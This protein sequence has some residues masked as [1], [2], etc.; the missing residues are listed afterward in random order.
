MKIYKKYWFTLP[1]LVVVITVLVVLSTV[2]FLTLITHSKDARDTVRISDMENIRTAMDTFYINNKIFPDPNWISITYSWSE[3]WN[4]WTISDQVI[5]NL[6]QI[7]KKPSDPLTDWEYPYSRLNS[8][9]QFQIWTIL[10]KSQ[11]LNITN[12][13]KAADSIW[14]IN[15]WHIYLEWNYNSLVSSVNIWNKIYALVVPAIITSDLTNTDFEY[16]LENRKILYHG[17][18]YNG[19]FVWL[20]FTPYSIVAYEWSWKELSNIKEQVKLMRTVKDLYCS[21]N[22]LEEGRAIQ[23]LLTNVINPNAPSFEYK[24]FANKFIRDNI[25]AGI[26]KY[27]EVSDTTSFACDWSDHNLSLNT[28]TW[29]NYHVTPNSNSFTALRKDWS[30]VSWWNV[31]Y[32][33]SWAPTDEWYIWVYSSLHSFTAIKPDWYVYTWWS[34][35]VYWAP[36]SWIETPNKDWFLEI[37]S[38]DDAYAILKDDECWT[39]STYWEPTSWWT[40]WPTDSWYRKIYSSGR[41]FAALK[42]DWT[43]TSWWAY[44]WV[45]PTWTWFVNIFSNRAAFAWLRNDWS[46]Y[47][48]WSWVADWDIAWT[49]RVDVTANAQAFTAINNSWEVFSWWNPSYW[50]WL[51]PSDS[52]ITKVIATSDDNL[53]A[54]AAILS[55][56]SIKVWWDNSKWWDQS[57]APAWTWWSNIYATEDTFVAVKPDSTLHTWWDIDNTTLVSDKYPTPTLTNNDKP[58]Q[59]IY[60][61]RWAIALITNKWEIKVWWRWWHWWNQALAPAWSWYNKIISNQFSFAATKPNWTIVTWWWSTWTPT[62]TYYWWWDWSPS[63]KWFVSLNWVCINE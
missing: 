28:Y 19:W 43:I 5:T 21:W 12:S 34:W 7:S 62:W 49:G 44:V 47:T 40:W 22:F 46:I 29:D 54:F 3:I 57:E 53:W 36:S 55:D 39:V 18:W 60:T 8:K 4:Q 13:A 27:R 6:T 31:N 11:A 37:A 15:D 50:A 26:R 17:I 16:L 10:E 1:E 52:W 48:R 56:W 2:V 58:I 61:N 14:T 32:W 59:W 51:H 20:R 35:S 33:G 42:F 38:S 9:E 41:S 45:P 30:V 25:Y 23:K 63:E 24:I